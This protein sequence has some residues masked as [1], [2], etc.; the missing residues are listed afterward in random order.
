MRRSKVSYHG[1]PQ[2][3]LVVF[4]AEIF[5]FS[6]RVSRIGTLF[7]ISP[8]F[9]TFNDIICR[10]RLPFFEGHVVRFR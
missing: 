10:G 3:R 1:Q 5:A 9:E 2:I 6:I 8:V 7:K 4:G